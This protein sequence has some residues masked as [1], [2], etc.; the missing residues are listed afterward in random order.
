[1][2]SSFLKHIKLYEKSTFTSLLGAIKRDEVIAAINQLNSNK[3]PGPDGLPAEFYQMCLDDII[4]LLTSVFN[5][6]LKNG[7]LCD[8]FYQGTM[9]LLYE[10][11]D[12]SNLDNYRQL[13]LINAVYKI[14]VINTHIRKTRAKVVIKQTSITGD[15]VFKNIITDLRKRK[16]NHRRT[17]NPLPWDV[18]N[19]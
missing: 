8:S 14:L 4:D 19:V 1:A 13:T 16:E 12:K 5:S 3:S 7:T 2:D 9:C 17:G 15:T 18:L 6:G 11:G 10:K